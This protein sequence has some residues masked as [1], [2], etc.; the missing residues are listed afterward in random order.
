[1]GIELDRLKYGPQTEGVTQG[2]FPDG[3]GPLHSFPGSVS[4]GASNYVVSYSGPLLNELLARNRTG[5]VAPWGTR[6]D[7]IEIANPADALVDLGGLGLSDRPGQPRWIIPPGTLIAPHG[8]VRIWCDDEMPASLATS[9]DLNTG[10]AL[11]ANSGGLYLFGL[12]GAVLDYV[13]HGFQADDRSIGRSQDGMWRLRA[14][15]TPA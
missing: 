4:P 8:F 1:A 11:S 5:I 2:R 13:E 14:S 10:F 12:S 15:P 3:T 6:A 9:P 7:W